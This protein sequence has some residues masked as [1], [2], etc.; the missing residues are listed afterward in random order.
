MSLS[1]GYRK[2]LIIKSNYY[3]QNTEVETYVKKHIDPLTN[4][5]RERL[6]KRDG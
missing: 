4:R 2:K 3:K 5:E 1:T 6:R